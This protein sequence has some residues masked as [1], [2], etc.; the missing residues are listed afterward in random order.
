M[1]IRDRGSTIKAG[2]Y[3]TKQMDYL[4]SKSTPCG[5]NAA[6][7]PMTVGTVTGYLGLISNHRYHGV[8][9]RKET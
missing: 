1:C 9:S 7:I 6:K 8:V 4:F 2:K 5:D 3:G